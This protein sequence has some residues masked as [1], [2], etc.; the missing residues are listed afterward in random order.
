MQAV[1]GEEKETLP[2]QD[3]H[4][5]DHDDSDYSSNDDQGP[6]PVSLRSPLAMN[7]RMI[8]CSW[9]SLTSPE[10][11]HGHENTHV[12]SMLDMSYQMVMILAMGG[13]TAMSYCLQYQ[14]S[15]PVQ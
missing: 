12:L 11:L 14:W 13:H 9:V 7:K 3:V 5:G 8:H 15:H 6:A 2:G 1:A 10:T 4:A